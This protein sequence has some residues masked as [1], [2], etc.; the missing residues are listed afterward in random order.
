[1]NIMN[2]I[3]AFSTLNLLIY[4]LFITMFYNKLF[5]KMWQ[6][7]QCLCYILLFSHGKDHIDQTNFTK[8]MTERVHDF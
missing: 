8:G 5:P 3:I 4:P 2:K 1:M 7:Q 6:A